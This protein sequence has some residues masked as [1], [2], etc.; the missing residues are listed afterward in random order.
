MSDLKRFL[1]TDMIGVPPF[2]F[3][4][5]QFMHVDLA[6]QIVYWDRDLNRFLTT[7]SIKCNPDKRMK[8]IC[9]MLFELMPIV[10]ISKELNGI[11]AYFYTGIEI[12]LSINPFLHTDKTEIT[13]KEIE[14]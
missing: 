9:K 12:Q 4:D 7:P 6:K 1:S 10:K 14:G 3:E 8:A 2:Y 11:L 13:R 5:G